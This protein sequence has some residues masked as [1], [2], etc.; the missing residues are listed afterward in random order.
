MTCESKPGKVRIVFDCATK[1]GGVS[2]NSEC[3]QGPDLCNKLLNVLLRFRQYDCALMADIKA[4]YLQVRE[5]E[6]DRD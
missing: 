5:P 4:V 6:I 2:L 1:C 3:Y